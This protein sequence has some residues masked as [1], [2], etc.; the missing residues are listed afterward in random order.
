MEILNTYVLPAVF[1]Y[2]AFISILNLL[3]MITLFAKTTID[4]PS[5]LWSQ[6]T[7][8]SSP[9]YWFN[10]QRATTVYFSF[11]FQIYYWSQHFDILNLLSF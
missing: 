10:P 7:R 11:M 3:F 1:V 9:K 2:T 6:G 4:L 8:L 5:L